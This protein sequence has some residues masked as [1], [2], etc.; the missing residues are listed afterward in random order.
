M[1]YNVQKNNLQLTKNKQHNI[2]NII[3][4]SLHH[5]TTY[6]TKIGRLKTKRRNKMDNEN[7]NYTNDVNNNNENQ[8]DLTLPKI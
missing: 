1:S 6:T 7:Y 2:I 4:N 3:L 5:L 8:F